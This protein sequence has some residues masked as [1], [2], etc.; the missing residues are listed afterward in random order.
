MTAAIEPV[1]QSRTAEAPEAF[2]KKYDYFLEQC[3]NDSRGFDIIEA[4]RYDD[5]S[6][7]D[8]YVDFECTFAAHFLA[9]MMQRNNNGG[10]PK[11]LDIGSYRHF[12]LGLLAHYYVTTVDVR[13][14]RPA[15]NHETTVTCD[16]K[17]LALPD[18]AF[19]AVVSLCAVEHFGLGR[20][21]DDFDLDADKHAFEEM[22]R[23]LKPRGALI[24]TT[25]LTGAKPQLAFNAH[26][27]YDY[28][29]IE[30][31]CKGLR[32]EGELFYLSSK[33]AFG[34][35]EEVTTKPGAWDIYCGCWIKPY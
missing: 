11:I 31:F 5:G 1:F 30:S 27:I 6:H 22:K 25:T 3:R 7:P 13:E 32:L 9:A 29:M 26:R 19:D 33:G 23:V 24:F 12:I 35:R 28:P 10:T 16:A 15:T 4:F 20:Y 21:G 17:K 18:R 14:R 34:P 2:R 8:T